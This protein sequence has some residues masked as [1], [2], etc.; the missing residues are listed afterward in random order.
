MTDTPD[1]IAGVL[2]LL[3]QCDREDTNPE[4]GQRFLYTREIRNLLGLPADQTHEQLAELL[5]YTEGN[6][7]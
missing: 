2:R 7:P 3:E 4:G 5:G 6:T 1:L